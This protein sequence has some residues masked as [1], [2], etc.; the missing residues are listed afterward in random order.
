[1]DYKHKTGERRRQ[2]QF[3]RSPAYKHYHTK[4]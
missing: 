3:A 1:M 4:G 2:L